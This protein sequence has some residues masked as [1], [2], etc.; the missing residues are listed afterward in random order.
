MISPND[1]L[2]LWRNRRIRICT[3][4]APAPKCSP[5]ILLAAPL[6]CVW[7]LLSQVPTVE[8]HRARI[9]QKLTVCN[10]SERSCYVF[11]AC[12]VCHRWLLHLRKSN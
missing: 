12:C 7:T 9:K 10:S 11:L 4:R 5:P 8:A 3:L 1:C 6:L 2:R